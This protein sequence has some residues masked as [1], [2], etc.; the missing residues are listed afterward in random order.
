MPIHVDS[1][2][3]IH[4]IRTLMQHD[5]AH[6]LEMRALVA[7]GD[8]PLGLRRVGLNATVEQSKALNDLRYPAI[9]ISASGMATGGRILHHLAY[10]LGDHRT[11][12]LFVGY[13]AAGTRGRA[14]QDGAKQIRIHGK[15]IAVRAQVETLDGMSAHADRGEMMDWLQAAERPPRKI[16]LVHGEPEASEALATLVREKSSIPIHVPRYLEKVKV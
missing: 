15:E 4:A 2:M 3:A 13:Q 12:V 7:N 5:E 6:D 1:P 16:F 8:D 11:T 9:I 14:L 10:R